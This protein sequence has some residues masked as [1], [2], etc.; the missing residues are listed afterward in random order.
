MVVVFSV[1]SVTVFVVGPSVVTEVSRVVSSVMVEVEL[2][3]LP[4]VSSVRFAVVVVAVAVVRT[5]VCTDVAVVVVL[6]FSRLT[7]VVV[8]VVLSSGT[9][10]WGGA[11]GWCPTAYSATLITATQATAVAVAGIR[12]TTGAKGRSALNRA[13]SAR[14]A[15]STAAFRSAGTGMA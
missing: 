2:S 1:V 13:C 6:L 4:V 10:V 11:G 9:G 7:D 3:V 14:Q 15:A 5:D 12:R 8:V